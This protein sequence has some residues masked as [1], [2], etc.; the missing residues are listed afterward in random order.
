MLLPM[1]TSGVVVIR[2]EE[3]KDVIRFGLVTCSE[4]VISEYDCGD[5]IKDRASVL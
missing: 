2:Y 5:P 1:K 3:S 4:N